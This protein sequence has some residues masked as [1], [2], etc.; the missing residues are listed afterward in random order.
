MPFPIAAIIGFVR[1][2][3][4]GI[5]VVIVAACLLG[6]AYLVFTARTLG[7][8]AKTVSGR[9][10]SVEPARSL[11]RVC[12]TDATRTRCGEISPGKLMSSTG[13]LTAG[14]CVRMKFARGAALSISRAACPS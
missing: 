13:T 3:W 14:E 4:L 10:A 11:T 6:A 2:K 9:V 12:V 1:R 8:G 5:A 7:G